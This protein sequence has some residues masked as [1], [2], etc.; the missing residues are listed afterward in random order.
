MLIKLRILDSR[1]R[2]GSLRGPSL[3]REV[4][5]RVGLR[6]MTSLGSRR[7]FPT[8]F[9][10]T[11][12]RLTSI[13]CL[14]LSPKKEEVKTHLARNLLVPSVVRSIRVTV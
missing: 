12:L 14:T 5:S 10:Q 3:M 6:F 1:G 4:L 7:G 11:S 2:M 8:K 13:T 9:F